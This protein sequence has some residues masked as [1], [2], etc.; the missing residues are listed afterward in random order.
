MVIIKAKIEIRRSMF[1]SGEK[2]GS[3]VCDVR[4]CGGRAKICKAGIAT[5]VM[6]LEFEGTLVVRNINLGT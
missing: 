1:F 6:L 3:Y 4:K 5:F 2:V